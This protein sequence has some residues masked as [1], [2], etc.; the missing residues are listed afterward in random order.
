MDSVITNLLDELEKELSQTKKGLF[1]DKS[2]VDADACLDI[3]AAKRLSLF[4]LALCNGYRRSFGFD[5][6]T[7]SYASAYVYKH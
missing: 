6:R 1:S 3:I 5:C 7:P 4:I 2:L